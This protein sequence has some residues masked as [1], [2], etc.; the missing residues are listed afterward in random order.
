MVK[1]TTPHETHS[2]K[3]SSPLLKTFL[4]ILALVLFCLIFV[5][6]DQ[7]YYNFINQHFPNVG[8][9]AWLATVFGVVSRLHV[10]IPCILL[11]GWHPRLFGFQTGKIFR[12]WKLILVLTTI[13][14]AVI[15]AYLWAS[16]STPYSGNQWLVTEVITVP[17]IEET[18]WR[19]L[20]FTALLTAL[21]K[22]YPEN[23]A[24]VWAIVLSSIAFGLL[25]SA[26]GLVGLSLQFVALQTI[27]ALIWGLVYGF[28]RAKTE[29]VYP[30]M[31]MH[32]AMNLVVILF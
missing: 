8:G 1:Q 18:L 32:A 6:A 21:R 15:G 25:H 23:A 30:S 5:L 29:S 16:G 17:F 24:S 4:I 19:G 12:N 7:A 14:C 2:P 3:K 28:V 22:I 26:N 10:L 9:S 13:N 31:L 11:A 20:V 27:N